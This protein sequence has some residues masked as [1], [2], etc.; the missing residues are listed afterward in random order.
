MQWLPSKLL[1]WLKCSVFIFYSVSFSFFLLNMVLVLHS[2]YSFERGNLKVLQLQMAI[3]TQMNA[4]VLKC[5]PFQNVNSDEI[6]FWNIIRKQF[7]QNR[8]LITTDEYCFFLVLYFYRIFH[9]PHRHFIL[10]EVV[11]FCTT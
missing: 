11:Y 2:I 4:A 8:E 9:I 6:L 10:F 3:I 7:M 5:Y 1:I